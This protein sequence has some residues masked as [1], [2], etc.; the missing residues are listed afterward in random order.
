MANSFQPLWQWLK[1]ADA[2]GVERARIPSSLDGVP[3]HSFTP[4]WK[5]NVSPTNNGH[6]ASRL[7]RIGSGRWVQVAYALIDTVLILLNG[8]VALALRFTPALSRDLSPRNRTNATDGIPYM[9]YFAFLLLYVVL[10]LLLC[11]S[12][13]L[14]RTLRTRAAV[15]ESFAVFKAVFLGTLLLTA[16]IYLSGIKT[17]SR[18]VVAYAGLLNIAALVTW[19]LWK[20]RLVLRRAERGIGTRNT[21]IIG[22]GRIGQ[23]LARQLEEN[24]LLGY[25]FKGF[26]DANH[27]TDPR[28]IGKIEDLP[29]IARAEFVDEVFITI[30]SE[31]ELVKN[32]AAVARRN[33]LNVKVI[34]ELYD[35][36]AWGASIQHVGDFPIME[37]HWE[38]I[39]AFG[40]FIKRSID[41]LGSGLGLI[42]LSPV[43]IVIGSAIR[44]S[45]HGPVIYRSLRLGK[46]G[47]NFVCYKFRTMVV[48]ADEVKQQLRHLNEREGPTFKITNDPRITR[49]GRLLRKYSL[50]E[51]PQLW[52]VLKGDMSLVGPR[53]HPLDDCQQYAL[54]HLRRLEVRPGI[55]GLWQITARKHPSFA[56]NMQLDLEYID[57]WNLWLDA[58][59]L[60]RTLPAAL[61]GSGV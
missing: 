48:N 26:L 40:L 59:I 1:F 7:D 38:P 32:V 58:K 5:P 34:P 23:A 14:Y 24:K 2:V 45:S 35:G 10:I 31:R 55:T 21:L 60:F 11:Q 9:H 15:E 47:R 17:I 39:P 57:S 46:K 43:L 33:R 51:L 52:N 22:A 25:K 8:V 54:D 36:L 6:T 42:I 49:L 53:P 4:E 29:R 37:L 61:S 28:L 50:D 20:R 41:V 30:P 18:L 19:R 3:T 56:T 13:S 27:S 16:F 44:L 12:Q